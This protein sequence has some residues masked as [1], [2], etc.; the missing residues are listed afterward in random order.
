MDRRTWQPTVLGDHKESDTT[1]QLNSSSMPKYRS[2]ERQDKDGR[3]KDDSQLDRQIE[4]SVKFSESD[5]LNLLQ[6]STNS[7]NCSLYIT[8]FFFWPHYS[9]GRILVP[10]SGIEPMAP[11]AGVQSFN[12]WTSKEVSSI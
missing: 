8:F 3:G 7:K 1:E 5:R 11:A 12:R 10:L 4:I 9:V 6:T 2:M